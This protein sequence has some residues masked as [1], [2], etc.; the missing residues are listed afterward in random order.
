M[1][2]LLLTPVESRANYVTLNM[3]AGEVWHR[4]KVKHRLRKVWV[5][6]PPSTEIA[7]FTDIFLM[8]H[9]CAKLVLSPDCPAIL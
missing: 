7:F 5:R 3:L 8:S 9:P 2:L 6:G 4:G 1:S